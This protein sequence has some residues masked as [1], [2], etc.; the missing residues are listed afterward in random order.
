MRN[1]NKARNF[2]DDNQNSSYNNRRGGY[3]SGGRNESRGKLSHNILPPPSILEAYE[4]LSEGAADKLFTM[5]EQ[6]QSHR[7]EWE[8]RYLSSHARAYRFGQFFGV[9]IAGLIAYYSFQMV[10]ADKSQEAI[11]LMIGGFSFLAVSS[12]AAA[13]GK[14][15]T[16]RHNRYNKNYKKPNHTTEKKEDSKA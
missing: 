15:F 2:S 16:K 8:N 3:K 14:Y 12:I 6:E 10:M 7:H 11:Y 9:I 4:G 1:E 5:A 13:K